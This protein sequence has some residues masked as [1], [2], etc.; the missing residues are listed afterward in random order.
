MD[1]AVNHFNKALKLL[2]N[3]QPTTK[4]SIYNRIM[5]EGIKQY[6]HIK[7]PSSYVGIVP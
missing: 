6:L 2:G 5:T 4:F 7:F 1:N 3:K